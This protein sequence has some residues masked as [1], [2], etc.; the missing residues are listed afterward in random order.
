MSLIHVREKRFIQSIFFQ[1]IQ[2]NNFMK[3]RHRQHTLQNRTGLL[4][5]RMYGLFHRRV[6]SIAGHGNSNVNVVPTQHTT[7][8]TILVDLVESIGSW[9]GEYHDYRHKKSKNEAEKPMVAGKG[10]LPSFF[11]FIFLWRE[12]KMKQK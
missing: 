5:C 12:K 8:A 11:F 3:E 6:V 7:A 1:V 9:I 2:M 10:V 4:F